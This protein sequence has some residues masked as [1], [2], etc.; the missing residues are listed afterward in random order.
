MDD[1]TGETPPVEPE[2]SNN[3]EPEASNN[4]EPEASN[5][6][7]PKAQP[8]PNLEG[9]RAELAKKEEE[10]AAE[11]NR[12]LRTYAEFDNYRKRIL[13]DQGEAARYGH[14]PL[15]RAL[16]PVGDNLERAILHAR[17]RQDASQLVEGLELIARQ[18]LDTL[19]KFGVTRIEAEGQ[20]FDPARHE[21]LERIVTEDRPE[22][23]VVEQTQAGYLLHDRLLRPA[24]VK[25]ATRQQL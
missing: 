15:I 24:L 22:G 18:F 2:A 1:S 5:I 16:L 17:E 20:P 11:Y 6:I 3:I 14:E 21:A 23:I 10:L 4:I 9:L 25:V 12:F 8:E 13:R 7:E 19:A